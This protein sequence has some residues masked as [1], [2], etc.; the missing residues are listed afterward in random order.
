MASL[1]LVEDH[2]LFRAGVRALIERSGS[3]H[4]VVGEAAE[5]HTA[6]RLAKELAPD[7]VMLDLS[8]PRLN[9]IEAAR[10]IT[11]ENPHVR[12]IM[13]SMHSDPGYINAAFDAGASAYV[14]KDAAFSELEAAIRSVLAG[15]KYLSQGVRATTALNGRAHP[16]PSGPD[17]GKLSSRERQV[18]QLIGEAN[19]SAEIATTLALSVRTVET[20]RQNMM[21]KLDLHSAA[22]LTSF[23]IKHGVC[24]VETMDRK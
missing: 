6:A 12:V 13:L 15:N 24:S 18:L 1:L 21:N 19:S 22:A 3:G 20:Y 23:A 17:L 5:G 11:K 8:M 10:L 9:G 4:L 7:V 14:L 2:T 16:G